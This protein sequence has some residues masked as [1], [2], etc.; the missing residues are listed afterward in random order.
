[1]KFSASK[2]M[3]LVAATAAVLAF[4]PVGGSQ[5]VYAQTPDIAKMFTNPDF[6][7]DF[8][9]MLNPEMMAT[10]MQVMANPEMMKAMM[11]FANPELFTPFMSVMTNPDRDNKINF[12][13]FVL[14]MMKI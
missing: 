9:S 14:M 6:T 7:S 2:R 1:M 10:W 8:S 5:A 3:A 11:S 13:D 4:S 12:K